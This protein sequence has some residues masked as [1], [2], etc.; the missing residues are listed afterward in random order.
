VSSLRS[1]TISSFQGR[2][3]TS[4]SV[5]S[6]SLY[7]SIICFTN[8]TFLHSTA[9][10]NTSSK[11]FSSSDNIS[12]NFA[13]VAGLSEITQQYSGILHAKLYVQI[14]LVI[15]IISCLSNEISGLKTKVSEALSI[16][17]IFSK[18]W[19]ETCP[20]LSHFTIA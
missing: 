6:L 7:S 18:V 13:Q 1:I 20:R 4:I 9:L 17:N 10:V 8:S 11:I 15:F 12:S 2:K 19:L 16:T 5:A 14:F 3:T